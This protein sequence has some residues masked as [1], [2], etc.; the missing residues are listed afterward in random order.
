[1]NHSHQSQQ[2]GNVSNQLNKPKSL[3]FK[4]IIASLIGIILLNFLVPHKNHVIDALPYLLIAAMFF[5]HLGGHG[6]HNHGGS[7]H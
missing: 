5:M 6:G 1:M 4:L 3:M 2:T 7:K